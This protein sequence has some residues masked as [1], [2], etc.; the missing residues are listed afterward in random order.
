VPTGVGRADA[1]EGR[2]HE[3]ARRAD[4]GR[5]RTAPPTAPSVPGSGRRHACP[6]QAV[7]GQ[8]EVDGD[9]VAVRL[10]EGSRPGAVPVGELLDRIAAR[11][12][13][14]GTGLG[15]AA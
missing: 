4:C 15:A 6:Y 8:R 2:A 12:G 14:R 5:N 3:V 11:V 1:R 10:R 9:L 7:I 13:D